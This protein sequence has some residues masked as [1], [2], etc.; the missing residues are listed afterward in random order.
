M[1]KRENGEKEL[2]IDI[3]HLLL[4]LLKKAWV[5]LIVGVIAG[6]AALAYTSC[7]VTPKYSSSVMLYVN[8]KSFS[9]GDTEVS[10]SASDL[11]ASQSL[12][13]TYMVILQNR[14]TMEEVAERSALGYNYKQLLSMVSTGEYVGTEVFYVTVTA[15]DPSHAAIIANCISEVLAER[16]EDIIDGASMRIVDTA[17]VNPNKVSPNITNSVIIAFLIGAVV[18]AAVFAVLIIFDDTIRGEDYLADNYDLPILARI[19]DLTSERSDDKYGYYK[20]SGYYGN[21]GSTR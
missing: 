1:S 3:R 19:P 13:D 12:I 5:I 15:E 8:N 9:L 14:T 6:A 21:G 11:S 7:F 18:T 17:V 16:I 2:I 20:S 4:S 10:I